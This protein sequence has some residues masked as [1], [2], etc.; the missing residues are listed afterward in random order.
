MFSRESRERLKETRTPRSETKTRFMTRMDAANSSSVNEVKTRSAIKEEK[1][2]EDDDSGSE[3]EQEVEIVSPEPD[4]KSYLV[5]L[6]IF[7]IS[8]KEIK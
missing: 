3:K 8:T 1:K 5:I 2:V 4:P 7:I 6:K